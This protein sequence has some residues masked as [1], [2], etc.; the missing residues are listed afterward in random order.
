MLTPTICSASP[1]WAMTRNSCAVPT[2]D[3][4]KPRACVA[5]F[6]SSSARDNGKGVLIKVLMR[7]LERAFAE[8]SGPEGLISPLPGPFG[9]AYAAADRHIIL[10]TNMRKK[11]ARYLAAESGARD[12]ARR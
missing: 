2:T 4:P 1:Y 11:S 6:A 12:F 10:S 5:Q 7:S 9:L 8:F 3:S